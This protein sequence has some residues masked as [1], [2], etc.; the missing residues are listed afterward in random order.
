MDCA[1]GPKGDPSFERRRLLRALAMV[2]IVAGSLPS[3][4]LAGCAAL[5]P[6]AAPT[7]LRP[8]P[9]RQDLGLPVEQ[10]TEVWSYN[11]SSPGPLLRFRQGDAVEIDVENALA[12]PTT[13]HWHG[14]R[15]PIAMDGVPHVSHP[16]IQPGARFR[17]RFSLK[18][19]GTYWYHPHFRGFEQVT[20]G[21][22]GALI[23]EEREPPLVDEDWAWV[24]A[25]WRLAPSG[26]LRAD[27]E[28]RFDMSHAGRI[29]NTVT[30]NG[31]LA[32]FSDADPRPLEVRAGTRIRLRLLNASV[33]RPYQL[34]FAGATPSIIAFDGQPVESHSVPEAGV[35]VG[36]GQRVDLMLDMP[37][38]NVTLRDR[39]DDRREYV[40]RTL[41]GKGNGPSRPP[42]KGLPPNPLPEPDME[43]AIRQTIILDGG[44]R[45]R[46]QSA[47]VHGKDV[48]IARLVREHG[49]A[50]AMNGVAAN[51]HVHEP[52]L[53]VPLGASVMLRIENR[54]SWSHPMH[55]HGHSFRVLSVDGKPTRYR[56]WR[57]TVMVDPNGV[58]EIAFVADNPGDWM[59]HCHILQH[60]QG[61]LMGA[62][63]VR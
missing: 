49:M 7:V 11:G 40:M 51:D 35:M 10:P 60:Q 36:A 1:G 55:L 31:K 15:V 21:L 14:L 3:W 29:G 41:V 8:A 39:F 46:M 63:R 52:L 28:D 62:L 16:P 5:Q 44:A 30:I 13:V 6:R 59:F 34:A 56:E 54:T 33:A 18:D 2:P 25:D 61:G 19:A 58:V 45:S 23:V 37:T 48:A 42:F 22:Y 27:F 47:K 43:R 38:G 9:A 24:I 12:E 32:M 26:A 53:T 4:L 50:W 20:R 17:Y 57:D